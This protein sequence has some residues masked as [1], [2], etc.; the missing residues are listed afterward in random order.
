MIRAPGVTP[1]DGA[2]CERFV[3]LLDIYPTLAELCDLEPPAHLDGRSL[4]PLL[5]NPEAQWES[6]AITGLTSKGGPPWYPYISIRNE[7]GRYIRYKDGQEEFYD[8]TKDPHEWTNHI[9]SPAY[10]PI[11][12]NMRAAIPTPSDAAIPLPMVLRNE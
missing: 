10:A 2:E 1:A 7:A 6:T 3:S 9:D 12:N 8:T 4:V 11:I 5:K